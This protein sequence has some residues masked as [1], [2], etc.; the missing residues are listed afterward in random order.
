MSSLTCSGEE[1]ACCVRSE[2]IYNFANVLL[3]IRFFS[4]GEYYLVSSHPTE[5]HIE[6]RY[7]FQ[8]LHSFRYRKI[9]KIKFNKAPT[10]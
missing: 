9:F 3:P 6:S 2:A 7:P 4:L 8:A 5:L 10:F 1:V